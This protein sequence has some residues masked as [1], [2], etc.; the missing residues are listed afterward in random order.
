[1]FST[2]ASF[3]EYITFLRSMEIDNPIE[4]LRIYDKYLIYDYNETRTTSS[5][6]NKGL[7]EHQM[8]MELD[9]TIDVIF[10]YLTN[11]M[12]EMEIFKN[13]NLNISYNNSPYKYMMDHKLNP[14]SLI[15][16][17]NLIK[18]FLLNNNDDDKTDYEDE[19]SYKK[20]L[21]IYLSISDYVK[22]GMKYLETKKDEIN[23]H[24]IGASLYD[25]HVKD[26]ITF[27]MDITTDDNYYGYKK[28]I[29]TH[30]KTE[31]KKNIDNG[32]IQYNISANNML[33]NN[34][35]STIMHALPYKNH[36]TNNNK[37]TFEKLLTIIYIDGD[38]DSDIETIK[39]FKREKLSNKMRDD[40]DKILLDWNDVCNI[41]LSY[42]YKSQ[43]KN[44]IQFY[45]SNI[46]NIYNDLIFMCLGYR[47][48][49]EEH[50]KEM[51]CYVAP[52]SNKSISELPS[53]I[54]S[55]LYMNLSDDIEYEINNNSNNSMINKLIKWHEL[56]TNKDNKTDY[57]INVRNIV[58]L[59]KCNEDDKKTFYKNHIIK[60][61]KK[62][63]A[64]FIDGYLKTTW[65]NL[66][67]FIMM[68]E[69]ID[70]VQKHL[71]LFFN[72]C[73]DEYALSALNFLK[74]YCSYP[75]F[76]YKDVKEDY[77]YDLRS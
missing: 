23:R 29:V 44:K 77:L 16:G 35:I 57:V 70:I 30:I 10:E 43:N 41:I 4:Q 32:Y 45:F 54:Y 38:I 62:Y 11:G 2:F 26:Y 61:I 3:S 59:I 49:F 25:L 42:P 8:S 75:K 24:V 47:D 73:K 31:L 50:K 22:Y 34:I 74:M 66:S 51:S 76:E 21:T 33:I 48:A 20:Y 64:K 12:C 63:N 52:M 36:K 15:F 9:Y 53:Y 39:K 18:V 7:E 60:Y 56:T 14:R 58:S 13:H 40:N 28:F 68:S 27:K 69:D 37:I 6:T 72:K 5:S 71:F 1:M 17:R 55:D 65:Y 19:S 67:M 46:T